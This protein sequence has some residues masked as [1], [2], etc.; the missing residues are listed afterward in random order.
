MPVAL[1]ALTAKFINGTLYAVGGVDISGTSSSTLA[2]DPKTNSWTEKAP[3]P[4]A[5]EHLTSEVLDEKL[6]VIGGRTAGMSANVDA[7]E[8][9]DPINDSWT[10]LPSMPSKRGGLTSAAVNE[11]IYVFGGEQPSGTFNNNEKYEP[12]T[13]TW[14]ISQPMPTARHGLAAVS[15]YDRIYVIGGGPEPGGSQTGLNEIFQSE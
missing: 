6:Y 9:Y 4:T 2:Y 15:I 13:N 12:R 1:G 5:R 8:V 3:M 7:T 14:S 10:E 11:T